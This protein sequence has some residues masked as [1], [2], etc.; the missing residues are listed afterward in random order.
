MNN[1]FQRESYET[2]NLAACSHNS[3][4]GRVIC[5]LIWSKSSTFESMNDHPR[6]GYVWSREL[7]GVA[8][9]LPANQGRSSLVHGLIHALDLLDTQSESIISRDENPEEVYPPTRRA[10]VIPPD[11]SLATESSLGQYHDTAYVGPSDHSPDLYLQTLMADMLYQRLPSE[12]RKV[13]RE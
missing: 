1:G 6:V 4:S 13:G 11:L 7:Q 10:L 12:I 8:D 5:T 9:Q 3:H 2:W